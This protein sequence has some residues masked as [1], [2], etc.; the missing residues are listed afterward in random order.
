MATPIGHGLVGM[1]LARR[2]GVRSPLGLAAAAI[3]AMSPDADLIPGIALHR[4]P[5]HFHR[6]LTHTTGFT[7]ALGMFAGFTGLLSAGNAEGERDLIADAL[8]GAAVVSSHV[9]VDRLRLP[10]YDISLKGTPVRRVLANEIRNSVADV[11]IYGTLAWLLWP[12]GDAADP[13]S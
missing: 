11:I 8:T 12:R 10:V 7:S 6:K 2:L 5:Y 13:A 4:D 9:L 1:L 3:G